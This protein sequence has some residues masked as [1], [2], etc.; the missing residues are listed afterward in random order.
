MLLF[1]KNTTYRTIHTDGRVLESDSEPSWSGYSVGKWDGDTLVVETN[2]LK[3]GH[4]AR[5]HRQ[6]NYANGQAD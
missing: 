5:L 3:E 2:G 6:P 1:E 4:M